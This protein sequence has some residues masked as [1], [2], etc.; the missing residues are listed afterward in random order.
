MPPAER[1]GEFIAHLEAYRSRL[2]KTQVMRIARLP[3]AN[4][5]RLRSDEFQMCLIAKA[6]GFGNCQRTFINMARDQCGGGRDKRCF[7]RELIFRVGWA[8]CLHAQCQVA[9]NR[10]LT[11]TIEARRARNRRRIIRVKT[12]R[13]LGRRYK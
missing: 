8:C 4:Q 6:F 5:T 11:T 7:V 1:D 12:N 2:S 3:A 9:S 13:Y 10:V